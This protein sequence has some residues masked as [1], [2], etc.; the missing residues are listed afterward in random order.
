MASWKV[1]RLRKHSAQDDRSFW[2]RSSSLVPKLRLGTHLLGKL[3]FP[4]F[5]SFAALRLCVRPLPFPLPKCNPG[6]RA[7]TNSH[8]IPD[9]NRCILLPM[10]PPSSLPLATAPALPPARRRRF[11]F[12]ALGLATALGVFGWGILHLFELRFS[13]GDVFPAYSTLRKDPLGAA[14][15]HDALASLPGLTVE[16]NVRPLAS[17][18]QPSKLRLGQLAT[19]DPSLLRHRSPR[20]FL[21]RRGRL[22][23]AFPVSAQR[24]G[25]L[26]RHLAAGRPRGAHLFCPRKVRSP[27]NVSK[28]FTAINPMATMQIRLRTGPFQPKGTPGNDP[29][30]PLPAP[31]PKGENR[32][33]VKAPARRQTPAG[34]RWEDLV[35]RWGI[36]FQREGK[37]ARAAATTPAA[38]A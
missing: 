8:S 23:V 22:R 19:L 7:A 17:L 37:P 38:E 4:L 9:R 15:F 14:V 24:M 36:D 18:A 13:S 16:R 26:G 31:S 21:P 32:S 27:K 5:S 29:A 34:L 10:P 3:C 2:E 25:T 12:A 20:L 33:P 28:S 6:M 30:K 35:D 11:P 1:L